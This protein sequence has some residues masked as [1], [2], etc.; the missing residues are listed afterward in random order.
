MLQ[1]PVWIGVQ[2]IPSRIPDNSVNQKGNLR[3]PVDKEEEVAL[4]GPQHAHPVPLLQLVQ[5]CPVV[6]IDAPPILYLLS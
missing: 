5:V 1:L 4:A 3:D 6:F 2:K